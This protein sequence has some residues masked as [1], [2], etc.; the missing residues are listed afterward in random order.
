MRKV[1]LQCDL[2]GLLLLMSWVI[3]PCWVLRTFRKAICC[4]LTSVAAVE[5][6]LNFLLAS[7]FGWS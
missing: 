1:C 5:A 7:H 3:H 6:W 4:E 2:S